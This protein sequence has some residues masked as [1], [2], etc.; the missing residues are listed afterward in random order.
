[1]TAAMVGWAHMPFGKHSEETVESMIVKVAVD[2]IHDAGI[3]PEEI[4]TA[5]SYT[6]PSLVF[7]L[8]TDTVLGSAEEVLAFANSRDE[9]T[10]VVLDLSRA[11]E[12]RAAMTGSGTGDGH[13]GASNWW[14]IAN[15]LGACYEGRSQAVGTNYSRGDETVLAIFFTRCK[16]TNPDDPQD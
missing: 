6:E 5:S 12:L 15:R 1:M 14:S 2:A 3:A 4:V 10:L 11:P 8:G 9:P 7:S 16:E 13:G